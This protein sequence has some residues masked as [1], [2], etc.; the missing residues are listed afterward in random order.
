[1]SFVE[2]IEAKVRAAIREDGQDSSQQG[3]DAFMTQLTISNP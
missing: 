3:Q 2:R 1:M